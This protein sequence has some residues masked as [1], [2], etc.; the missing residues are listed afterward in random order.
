MSRLERLPVRLADHYGPATL[1][2]WQL[3][4]PAAEDPTSS[5]YWR[6]ALSWDELAQQYQQQ[7]DAPFVLICDALSLDA[8]IVLNRPYLVFARSITVSDAARVILDR[9]SG[10][11]GG[12]TLFAQ[13]VVNRADGQPRAL[14]LCRIETVTDEPVESTSDFLPEPSAA[15]VGCKWTAGAFERIELNTIDP[16]HLSPDTPLYSALTTQ[17]QIATL[18]SSEQ[19]ELSLAQLRWISA[20]GLI[21]PDT[22]ELAAQAAAMAIELSAARA[23]PDGAVLVPPLD[24]ALYSSAAGTLTDL[25]RSRQRNWEAISAMQTDD[26]RWAQAALEALGDRDSQLDLAKKLEKQ[27]SEARQQ[28]LAARQLAAQL[29]VETQAQIRLREIDF[30]LGIKRW[31]EEQIGREIFGL[32]TG[33]FQ[34]LAQIP[35]LMSAGPLLPALSAAQAAGSAA[36]SLVINTPPAGGST[37]LSPE[38]REKRQNALIEGLKSGFEGG[39]KVVDAALNISRIIANAEAMEAASE[40]LYRH[41]DSSVEQSMSNF[42]LSGLDQVTGGAQAW[43]I[44][45][46]TIEDA[47]D[48]L[49]GGVLLSVPGGSAYRLEFRKLIAYGKSLSEARLAMIRATAQLVE[50]KLRRQA[51]EQAQAAAQQSV[52]RHQQIGARRERL[53]QQAFSKVLDAKRAVYLAMEAY[54]RAYLYFTLADESAT[55]PLPRLTDP[56]ERFEA[57][58]IGLSSRLLLAQTLSKPPQTMDEVEIVLDDAALLASL[59]ERGEVSWT[60]PSDH[61]AFHGFGR[62]RLQRVRAFLEGVVKPG[63]IAVQ[64]RTA[65]HYRDRRLDGTLR[66][67]VGEPLS[68]QFVYQ[69]DT[70][71]IRFDGDI[72][73]RYE[74]DYFTPTPFTTWTLRFVRQDGQALDLTQVKQLIVKFYGEASSLTRH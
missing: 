23:V 53:A 7:P 21:S 66:E 45:S 41:I 16:A 17:F 58:V 62:V 39:Q 52:S 6:L 30:Q 40:Q 56:L 8:D 61:P 12:L 38:E 54:R 72:A 31:Q 36:G 42:E 10:A 33:A 65:G 73:R 63:E 18:L 37:G 9:T 44:L 70:R 64:I 25:L 60:L 74:N 68:K 26:A 2:A 32:V 1:Q 11:E 48:N 69:A 14:R 27:S 20:L 35:A 47:F 59:Q 71:R 28:A 15:A 49:G 43:E 57:A 4:L 24:Q 67:F 55:P 29:V 13:E 5:Q 50:L 19:P 46:H 22:R 3:P 34:L 51:A